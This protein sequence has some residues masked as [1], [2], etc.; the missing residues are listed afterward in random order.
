MPTY[1]PMSGE[2]IRRACEEAVAL[3]TEQED[4]EFIFNGQKI[5][6]KWSD[7]PAR[8]AADYTAE[9]ERRHKEYLAS[10]EYATREAER[11]Q[12]DESGRALLRSVLSVAPER[13]TF[14]DGG[15]EKWRDGL[16][17]NADPYGSAI[18]AYAE[19]WARVME[20]RIASG[21][22]VEGCAA[23]ASHVADA[24]GIT[25]F[26]YG[27]AVSVLAATWIHGEALRRWHNAK[28][29]QGGDGV[30]NPAILVIDD[31]PKPEQ[32]NDTAA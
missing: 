5:L 19:T 20:A 11:R 4:V 23:D 17:N 21:Y 12:R 29:G 6:A 16:G 3:A 31:K 24:D 14:S 27:A 9:T 10:P 7:N 13:M 26:M 32:A 22:T 8:L 28:Y 30:V 18:Y 25:G 15:E 2:S 1:E